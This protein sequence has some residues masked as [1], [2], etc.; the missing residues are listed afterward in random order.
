MERMIKMMK[1]ILMI[2]AM[3]L[4]AAAILPSGKGSEGLLK[5]TGLRQEAYAAKAT[6][7]YVAGKSGDYN[8][9]GGCYDR[10]YTTLENGQSIHNT[11]SE[12]AGTAEFNAGV[13]TL[14]NYVFNGYGMYKYYIDSYCIYAEGDLE[15]R[16]KGNCEL[17]N[18]SLYVEDLPYYTGSVPRGLYGIY[19]DGNLTITN[20]DSE[21]GSLKVETT[22]YPVYHSCGICCKGLTIKNSGSETVNVSS[23]AGSVEH[24]Y[25]SA[26]DYSYGV[27]IKPGGDGLNMQSG[28]LYVRSGGFINNSKT[29]CRSYGLYT[30]NG[31]TV[32]GGTISLD[33][34]G[35]SC[36][37]AGMFLS[38]PG[39]TYTLNITGGEINTGS[40]GVKYGIE[41]D[42]K[43]YNINISQGEIV[44]KGGIKAI[45]NENNVK[46]PVM[47]GSANSTSGFNLQESN[48]YVDSWKYA[49]LD[50]NQL[51]VTATDWTYGDDKTVDWTPKHSGDPVSYIYHGINETYY[52][53]GECPVDAGDYTVTVTYRDSRQTGKADFSIAKRDLTDEKVVLTINPDDQRTYDGM[54]QQAVYTLKNNGKDMVEG[55]DYT[56]TG[57]TATDVGDNTITFT[58]IGNC[59]GSISATW[60][61]KK[62][63]PVFQNYNVPPEDFTETRAKEYDG[64]AEHIFIPTLKS[65]FTGGGEIRLHTVGRDGTVYDSDEPP[66]NV[67]KYKVTFS[68]G[69]G[70]NFTASDNIYYWNLDITKTRH[71]D[72]N[73]LT[74]VGQAGV[75][76]ILDFSDYIEEGGYIKDI[77]GVLEG[78]IMEYRKKTNGAKGENS[79]VRFKFKGD[80]VGKTYNMALSIYGCDNFADNY[81]LRI[82]LT[83]VKSHDHNLD[84]L[85]HVTR[86]EP[87]CERDGNLEYY[88]CE[89][90]GGFFRDVEGKSAFV[91][92]KDVI[93]PKKGHMLG[94]YTVTKNPGCV[95]KGKESQICSVCGEVLSSREIDPLG[96]DMGD[97]VIT[98]RPTGTEEGERTRSCSRC[99]YKETEEI[100][101]TEEEGDDPSGKLRDRVPLIGDEKYPS[102]ND[103]FAPLTASGK[104][105]TLELDFSNVSK[106]DVKP[107]AL[108][109]T[110]IK[111]TKL[112]TVSGVKDKDSVKGTGGVKALFNTKSGKAEITCKKSG[113]AEL[114]ME[115]DKTYVITFTVDT[116]KPVK[117][118][119][120]VGVGAEP[121]IKT[122]KELFGT[123]IDSG[124]LYAKSKKGASGVTV[125]S[126]SLMIDPAGNDSIT[127][128]YQYLNK[129][130]KTNIKVK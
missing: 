51:N 67:G 12:G 100:P 49:D 19:V 11:V 18:N 112:T 90:C 33:G 99:D 124:K 42:R 15:I 129:K 91:D 34:S 98:R 29:N 8:S 110:V 96:H 85:E 113:T 46:A 60:S 73:G 79:A 82:T 13:L 16:V 27:W 1:R 44:A 52:H 93:I 111:G 92:R 88:E 25:N 120:D 78:P 37:S 108:R 6:K 65:P 122:V 69:E 41:F 48:T 54:S 43:K 84:T 104:I 53:S 74:G 36:E 30:E 116:P 31:I 89:E 86:E 107:D 77:Y 22:R 123:D 121:V 128:Q 62:M 3:L 10:D 4:I 83:S 115:D 21:H 106:S 5:N 117:S 109:M 47:K 68:T 58:G 72:V 14:D 75:E 126:N 81:R 130:Y 119:R 56:V 102:A 70:K 7:V 9:S 118:A 95:S 40:G 55:T 38:Y 105:N 127:V 103:N 76:T 114:T 2:T 80:S 20:V 57:D 101:K 59:T 23:M 94:D 50:G 61:L 35:N 28:S 26:G 63:E 64:K 17:I 32:A 45:Y 24:G 66:V 97:W 71:G 125:S 39:D 87:S